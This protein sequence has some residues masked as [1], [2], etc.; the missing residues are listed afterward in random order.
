[1]RRDP[2]QGVR[3]CLCPW[4]GYTLDAATAPREPNS[5]RPAPGD[6]SVC[7]SC[8]AVSLYDDQLAVRRATDAELAEVMQLPDV[9]LYV[10]TI[11]ELRA[12]SPSIDEQ[13]G[14]IH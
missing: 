13:R 10:E 12:G 2:R 7:F 4:C 3:P 1:M 11:K 8:A 6:V 5:K 9:R 14:P